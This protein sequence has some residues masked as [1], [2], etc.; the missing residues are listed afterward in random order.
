[1]F[2]WSRQHRANLPTTQNTATQEKEGEN[3]MRELKGYLSEKTGVPIDHIR[4]VFKG[5]V[6][7]S[8]LPLDVQEIDSLVMLGSTDEM[9]QPP[10]RWQQ[11]R[12]IDDLQT[13]G[14]AHRAT[15]PRGGGNGSF[16]GERLYNPYCFERIETL[17]GLKDDEKARSIL[18]ELA[19]DPYI[20]QVMKNHKWKVGC[21]AEM[22]PEGLVG[23]D[24]VCIL[25]LNQNKG[26]KIL[27]RLR[28]DDLEGFRRIS[29]IRET[30]YHELA[31]NEFGE[32]D[33]HF[34]ALFRQVKKEV[35]E[36]D[37]TKQAGGKVIGGSLRAAPI[38]YG[39]GVDKE[40]RVHVHRLGGQAMS[41]DVTASEAAGSAAIHRLSVEEMEAQNSCGCK[42]TNSVSTLVMEQQQCLECVFDVKD[43][44]LPPKNETT[45]SEAATITIVFDRENTLRS[46]M[47][48]VDES[49]ASCM[50]LDA[51][52]PIERL[53]ILRSGIEKLIE[54]EVNGQEQLKACYNV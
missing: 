43:S 21:L 4:L 19:N 14:V 23:V 17:R 2:S 52:A 9:P 24:E 49:I 34:W 1:M 30:L 10:P 37:W 12:V 45:D 25:G 40:S 22:Y 16:S 46:V 7:S 26:E 11:T 27:L 50:S 8:S 31:H 35:T 48:S 42:E 39:A 15:S 29:V 32:H 5:V 36:M 3:E 51:T 18:E 6:L 38:A 28:T 20:L 33:K 54:F 13:D 47:M 53:F 41:T 44:A